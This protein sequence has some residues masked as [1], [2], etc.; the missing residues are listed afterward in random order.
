MACSVITFVSCN[1]NAEN[2][3][4]ADT[5]T[6]DMVTTNTTGD[7]SAMADEFETNSNAGRYYDARSG[8]PIR[9][10]VD[11]TTGTKTNASTN[12]PI[13]R[14]IYVMDDEWW[15]YDNQGNRLGK[16][17]MENN[18]VWYEGDDGKWVD[19]DTKWKMEDDEMKMK[20][21]DT[22]IKVEDDESKIK[23][24]NMKIK[25]EDGE[26]KVKTDN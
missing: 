21:G 2:T 11:R 3:G 15:A 18:Q 26:T 9:I 16:A 23:T 6:T 25:R 10:S 8:Q 17:K 19:Y 13:N 5:T 20:S 22:K 1:D 12:E 14:Y 4:D 24:E 7:Y